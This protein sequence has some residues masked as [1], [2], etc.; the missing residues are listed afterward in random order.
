MLDIILYSYNTFVYETKKL[1]LIEL[2]FN[3]GRG[4]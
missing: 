3:G 2:R 4:E 1:L